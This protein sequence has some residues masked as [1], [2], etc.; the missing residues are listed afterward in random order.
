V[1]LGPDDDRVN[2]LVHPAVTKKFVFAAD[3]NVLCPY[4]KPISL[5]KY[6]I[7]RFSP[8][9]SYILDGCS[10]SG[11]GAV[12]GVL[13]GRNVLVVEMDSRCVSGIR[14][15]LASNIIDEAAGEVQLDERGKPKPTTD[16]AGPS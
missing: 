9:D 8:Q 6:L 10:G 13:S 12:A 15:R 2:V 4:Q 7:S 5:Y 14:A 1:A 11:T 3:G 16:I